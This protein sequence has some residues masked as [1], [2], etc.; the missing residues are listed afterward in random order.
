[1]KA[2]R[3]L[4]KPLARHQPIAAA[5]KRNREKVRRASQRG[6]VPGREFLRS[7]S[8]LRFHDGV[9]LCAN[10]VSIC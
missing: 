1:M 3:A 4:Q 5:E 2:K 6:V 10:E 7:S 9:L 8:D